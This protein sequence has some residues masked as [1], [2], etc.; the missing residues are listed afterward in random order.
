MTILFIV[1]YENSIDLERQVTEVATNV[2]VIIMFIHIDPM[3]ALGQHINDF[4]IT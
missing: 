3:R 1:T 2:T 4:I